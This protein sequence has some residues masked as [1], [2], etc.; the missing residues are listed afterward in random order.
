MASEN[1]VHK[2]AC[3][4]GTNRFSVR[5]QP[6]MRAMCHCHF[7]QD[8]NQAP[9]GDFVVYRATQLETEETGSTVFKSFSAMNMVMRGTC[10]H[11]RKPVIERAR[12]PLFP[13]LLL[14]PVVNHPDRD[15]LPAPQLQMFSH[16]RV[17]DVGA[18]VPE[19][20][21]FISSEIQ[22]LWKLMRAL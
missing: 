18:H 19:Y 9:Y 22:F 4:C 11:C 1:T 20:S 6:V 13:K 2:F 21:G 16:R 7:C 3:S 14:V 12:I 8:Y 10:S 5:G 17:A 15:S